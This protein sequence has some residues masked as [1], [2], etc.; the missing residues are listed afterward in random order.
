MPGLALDR[1]SVRPE[2][3]SYYNAHGSGTLQ[4]DVA[5]RTLLAEL[6]DDRPLI[7]SIKPLTGHCMGAAAGIEIVA[8]ALAYDGGTVAAPPIVAEA[9][10]RLLD[11]IGP[12]E[13]GYTVKTSLGMGGHNSVVVL[14]PAG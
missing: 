4:C 6:F 13:G 1:A 3:V 9:H 8:T 10:P 2:D 11:G 5:E 7:H 12:F 14:G